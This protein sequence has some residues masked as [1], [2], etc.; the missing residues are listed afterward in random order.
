MCS[1][2]L[3]LFL[4]TL[5]VAVGVTLAA[6]AFVT[7]TAPSNPAHRGVYPER[8]PQEHKSSLHGLPAGHIYGARDVPGV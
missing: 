1:S 2:R 3:S 6:V 8:K 5:L 7:A 4:H